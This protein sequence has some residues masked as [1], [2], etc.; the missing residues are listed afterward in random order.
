ME[1]GQGLRLARVQKPESTGVF[2]FL[3]G[4]TEDFSLFGSG[5]FPLD[6]TL[7]FIGFHLEEEVL[8]P[9]G[10]FVILPE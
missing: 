1:E 4:E 9:F 10:F 2:R 3:L 7:E 8:N 6:L 5:G